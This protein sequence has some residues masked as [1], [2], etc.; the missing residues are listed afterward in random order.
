M[1]STNSHLHC[2]K[3]GNVLFA[4]PSED[5]LLPAVDYRSVR[6]CQIAPGV[7]DHFVYLYDYGDSWEH[8]IVAEKVLPVEQNIRCPLCSDGRR[9]CPPEDVGGVWGYADFLEAIRDARHPEH[10]RMLEWVGG[11]FDPEEFVSERINR[12]L[13]SFQSSLARSRM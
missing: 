1:G 10:I 6:L 9:A 7:K 11:A 3:V 2:F 13:R 4:E 8:E 12:M 5:D